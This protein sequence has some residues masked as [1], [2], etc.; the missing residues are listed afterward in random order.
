M[1]HEITHLKVEEDA[2][3][4]RLDR[5]LKKKL[6]KTPYALIQKMLR[7]GQVR[8]DGK[9]AK[10]ETRLEVGQDV[11]LPPAEQK[12]EKLTFRAQKG[13]R[14]FL[15]SITLFD[16]G[17]LLILNKPYGLAVQ[18][19]PNI[20]RHIDGMLAELRNLKGVQPR[21][22][23]RLDRDTSGI[24]VCG[25][26]LSATREMGDIFV[27]R[28]IKKIYWAVVSPAP[29]KDKGEIVGAIAKGTGKRK[30]AMVIDENEGKA[31]KTMYRVIERT[32]DNHAA[33]VAF[34]PRTGRMHQI[35]I[36]TA[37]VLGC[38]ILGDEKYDCKG[39]IIEEFDL[40]GRLHLHAARLMFRHPKTREIMD[41]SAPLP[42]ELEVTWKKL[43][44]NA[45]YD[46]DPFAD[47]IP[48]DLKPEKKDK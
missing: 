48:K 38:P 43:G 45:A 23:H 27:N 11:R 35:R 46:D 21:L 6:P 40:D 31:S 2:D 16:D 15:D 33:F 13:D 3:G 41:V 10:A 9:R 39:H 14:E 20:T 5:W 4:Q 28:D 18:G 30:E 24:L 7:T 36:H 26:S 29:A 17:Q 19:G 34:W 32:K 25:R 44:F 12:T 22:V 37:D 1:N 42:S 8:V 47:I